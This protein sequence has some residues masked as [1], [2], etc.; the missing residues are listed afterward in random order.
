MTWLATYPNERVGITLDDIEHSYK[1][2]SAPERISSLQKRIAN[3][4]G[5]QKRLV[6]KIN[7]K[8]VGTA[9][10][11]ITEEVND[12]QTIYVLPEFQGKGVGKALWNKIKTFSD[13]KKDFI[14]KVADYNDQAINFYK[15]IGFIDT[16]KRWL[17]EQFRLKS[18]TK[19]PEMEMRISAK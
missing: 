9:T 8:V 7:G 5:N 10:L 1:D 14:V 18:G 2:S 13:P 12:L 4:P 16:G 19:L 6:A 3:T 15:K 11:V 17:D